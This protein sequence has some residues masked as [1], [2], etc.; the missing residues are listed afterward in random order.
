MRPAQPRVWD[1]FGRT[2]AGD[3][4]GGAVQRFGFDI[5]GSKPDIIPAT[6]GA[7]VY[8]DDY[9]ALHRKLAAQPSAQGEPQCDRSRQINMDRD[10]LWVENGIPAAQPEPSALPVAWK[11]RSDAEI[12]VL[13]DKLFPMWR[14][15]IQPQFVLRLARAVLADASPTAQPV[16]APAG[17]NQWIPVTDHFPP[18]SE[19]DEFL[20]FSESH[21]FGGNEHFCTLKGSDFYEFDP[22]ETDNPGTP[23]SKC[24]TH[25]MQLPWPPA[26]ASAPAA[27]AQPEPTNP[28]ECAAIG[29]TLGAWS[30]KN[31]AAWMSGTNHVG[32]CNRWC[33]NRR[34]CP[35]T[36]SADERFVREMIEQGYEDAVAAQP[37]PS[38]QPVAMEQRLIEIAKALPEMATLGWVEGGMCEPDAAIKGYTKKQ[39]LA[40]L[41]EHWVDASP[42]AQP[43][44]VPAVTDAQINGAIRAQQFWRIAAQESGFSFGPELH[45]FARAVLALA[46][47]PAAPAQAVPL[48][49]AQTIAL[50]HQDHEAHQRLSAF[51]WFAAGVI[52]AERA[53]KISTGEVG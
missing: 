21:T 45:D 15:D 8:Y 30:C 41:A 35:A 16:A 3:E 49:D 11:E 34:E 10:R 26:L 51:E 25:W 20:C 5:S 23:T 37:G 31:A 50:W 38:A 22:D 4:T 42:T 40:I 32:R 27:P 36:D 6:N 1:E 52:A 7:F 13:A 28:C 29:E 46:S 9:L 39:V 43:V 12:L 17:C 33:G 18:F 53:H 19:E 24:I 48:T 14:E 44:A 47:A 2:N